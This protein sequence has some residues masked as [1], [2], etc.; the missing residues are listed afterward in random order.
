MRQLLIIISLIFISAPAFAQDAPFLNIQEVRSKGGIT[1]WLVEDHSLPLISLQFSFQDAGTIHDPD[2]LQGR[3]QLLSNTMDEGAGD[4]DS[5][6]FQKTLSDNSITLRFSSSRDNFGGN[7]KTLTRTKDLAFNLLKLALT[8]PRFD[9]APVKRMRLANITRIQSSI[10]NP[11]W[12]AARIMN[13]VAY[14]DHPYALNSGGTLDTLKNITPSDL[15][16]IAK[17]RLGKDRLFVS[18]TGDITAEELTAELDK[19]F[20][21]LP[22][23]TPLPEVEKTT[24][25]NQGTLAL[26]KQDIPQTIIQIMMPAFGRE[27][28]DYYA[29]QVMNYIFGG[30]GFG[31]KLMEEARE[32]RGLTYGIYSSTN[33]MRYA[34]SI[35]ISTSTKNE[36]AAEIMDVIRQQ[37]TVM[38][39]S[40]VDEKTLQDAKSYLTGSM[41]LSLTSTDSIAGMALS[42][43]IKD[44]PIDYLDHYADNINAVTATDVQRVAARLLKPDA[45]TIVMVGNPENIEPTTLVET[46]PNVE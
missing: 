27:D 8:Q 3:T 28:P 39:T 22:S 12:M 24:I 42:M 6:N 41:P 29:L 15:R 11:Q 2:A 40:A 37:M 23:D 4:K 20:G 19:I 46:L 10:S 34:D 25:Q 16:K 26:Y 36:T 18:V 32:K 1:A 45:M 30:A 14:K 9:A 5:Q 17:S 13:D 7:V 44:L 31:S 43:Q 21:S 33:D 38:K 35:T